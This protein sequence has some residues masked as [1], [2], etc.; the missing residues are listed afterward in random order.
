MKISGFEV[1]TAGNRVRASARVTWEDSAR[2]E[3]TVFIETPD[4]VSP[5]VSANPHAFLLA[6]IPPALRYGERRVLLDAELCPVLKDGLVSAVAILHDWYYQGRRPPLRVEARALRRGLAEPTATRAGF[7]FSGGID[8]YAALALNRQSFHD[9]HPYSIKDGILIFGLEQ[10][11]PAKFEHVTEFLGRAARACGLT[12]VPVYTNMY[13]PYRREDART[14]YDFWQLEFMG[15]ALASVAHALSSRVSLAWIGATDSHRTLRPH[16]SH[17][18]LDPS[19]GSGD[20]RIFHSGIALSRLEKT[21]L[22]AE[23]GTPLKHL[24][25]CNHYARYERGVV[26]CGECEK[27]LR[28][29]LAFLALDVLHEVAVFSN[30]DVTAD[31]IERRVRI[32]TDYKREC[33]QELLA[34]L[35]RKGHQ[36]IARRLE[37]KL[38]DYR[39]WGPVATNGKAQSLQR[40]VLRKL[41]HLARGGSLSGR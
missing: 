22:I 28:T 19:F 5:G 16:G 23:W 26:N 37:R 20:V 27:C 35:T 12:L 25:V 40:R 31:M 24:R 34:P 41:A 36:D 29:K 6:C 17:P 9:D 15:A 18:L 38:K 8:A 2:P 10:D 13:L 39:R 1:T 7:F 21:R 4:T 33:Y 32:T 30:P 11:D 3:D 14:G